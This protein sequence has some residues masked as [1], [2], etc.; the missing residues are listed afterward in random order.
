MN[1]SRDDL[2]V[3]Y[4]KY[5]DMFYEV[6]SDDYFAPYFFEK[7]T[8]G[9]NTVSQINIQE[10]K[11]FDEQWIQTIESYFPSLNKIILN[12]KSALKYE[13]EVVAIEKAKKITSQSVRHLASNSHL[14]KEVREDGMVMPKKI[15]TT[16]SDVNY[17]VYENRFI[18][19][20]ID[21]LF[22]F[23]RKRY[24]AI[25][26]NYES[27]QK[28]HLNVNSVF[29]ID[30]REVAIKLD[31]TIKEAPDNK[32]INDYNLKLL[33][34]VENLNKLV[35]SLKQSKFMETMAKE[36]KV[37]PPI[38]KTQVI[39]KNVDYKNA[40]MLWLFLDRYNTLAFTTEIKEKNLGIDQAYVDDIYRNLLTTFM[41]F[42]A[43]Q[44][45][46][47]QLYAETKE[48]VMKR[49]SMKFV[50]KSA[51]DF[52]IRPEDEIIEAE[53]M[54]QYYLEQMK[55]LFKRS[56]EYHETQAKTYETT[57]KRA[58]RDT[59]NISN[60]LYKSFFELDDE[61]NIFSRMVK[62]KDP[63]KSLNDA[64]KK[65]QIA[66]MIR[67]VKQVDYNDS[68]R[69]ERRY[70]KEIERANKRLLEANI[71]N[72]L[73]T[74]KTVKS[75]AQIENDLRI[76]KKREELVKKKLLEV[77][78]SKQEILLDKV[79]VKDEI[80][81]YRNTLKAEEAKVIKAIKDEYNKK[82]RAEIKAL[83]EKHKKELKKLAAE[84]KRKQEQLKRQRE[85]EKLRL[86]KA[87]ERRIAKEKERAKIQAE[88]AI[89]R[90]K[91]TLA[92]QLKEKTDNV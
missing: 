52:M 86:K 42:E 46:R 51:N 3:F 8:G 29:P 71:K 84:K 63:V 2:L 14:I 73:I 49:K 81:A 15:Q 23:V 77:R 65:A 75:K 62:D 57:L 50:R 53:A 74:A 1:K 60:S 26:D 19:T 4:E 6:E 39:L 17:G 59:I 78:E 91:Q 55:T 31:V 72:K 64:K 89:E 40:Y 33:Q 45:K 34:R 25:K 67:E 32:K 36:K 20:L 27:F 80:K 10:T 9:K 35:S 12:P 85:Q 68:L 37:I 56:V 83:E 90:K 54:N 69:L 79:S 16:F 66:R 43:N 5:I 13:D 47:R 44:E 7:V 58:L 22:L 21:R 48:R 61:D 82:R 76:N 30:D 87:Q 41:T 88:K 11:T 92:K 18:M 38:M 28:K 24:E 70:L